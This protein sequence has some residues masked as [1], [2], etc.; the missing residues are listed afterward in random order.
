MHLLNRLFKRNLFGRLV[1]E[2]LRGEDVREHFINR[3]CLS[4][5]MNPEEWEVEDDKAEHR[6]HVVVQAQS[7]TR[8]AGTI[9][10]R[11]DMIAIIIHPTMIVPPE[12]DRKKLFDA[13]DYLA[14]NKILESL[15]MN[16]AEI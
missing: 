12:E 9:D 4:M 3:V 7:D 10:S 2:R 16:S 15:S 14:K 6:S 11:K 5:K 8:Y 13:F 1:A